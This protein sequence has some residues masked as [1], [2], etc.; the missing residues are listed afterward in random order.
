MVVL[1]AT[2]LPY[3]RSSADLTQASLASRPASFP[4]CFRSDLSQLYPLSD[5]QLISSADALASCSDAQS[6][7]WAQY[8]RALLIISTSSWLEDFSLALVQQLPT[9][10]ARHLSLSLLIRRL[11]VSLQ[12]MRISQIP[13]KQMPNTLIQFIQLLLLP[14]LDSRRRRPSWMRG[15][16]RRSIMA[17]T[18]MATNG[19]SQPPSHRLLLHP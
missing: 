2:S 7:S 10:Y 1:W 11:V 13:C 3:L 12:G 6:S 8:C 5:R 17:H 19:I 14:R 9:A 16:P 18:N 4:A 15:V